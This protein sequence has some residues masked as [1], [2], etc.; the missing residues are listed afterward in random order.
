MSALPTTVRGKVGLSGALAM[1]MALLGYFEGDRLVA[2]LDSVGV[3]TICKGVTQGVKLGDTYTQAEC[4]AKT[5]AALLLIAADVDRLVKVPITE[6]EQAAWYSFTYN[7]GAGAFG[8][9]TALRKLNAGDHIGACN[10]MLRWNK[11]GG[12][13]L[14]GLVKR[15]AAERELCLYSYAPYS[16]TLSPQP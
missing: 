10:E 3:P 7:V 2:Y 1:T 16:P 11:A 13:V 4:D 12:K 6:T 9:S 15:R 5:T 14:K 8:K